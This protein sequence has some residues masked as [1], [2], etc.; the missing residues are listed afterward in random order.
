MLDIAVIDLCA[1]YLFVMISLLVYDT[2]HI[3]AYLGSYPEFLGLMMLSV[4][5]VSNI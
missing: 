3:V 5:S 1:F 4:S 2:L